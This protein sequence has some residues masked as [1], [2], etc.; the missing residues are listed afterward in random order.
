M[1]LNDV[2]KPVKAEGNLVKIINVFNFSLDDVIN[3]QYKGSNKVEYTNCKYII[4]LAADHIDESV[5]N[6]ELVS[7]TEYTILREYLQKVS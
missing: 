3:G 2:N 4:E 7:K 5:D 6:T 1:Q